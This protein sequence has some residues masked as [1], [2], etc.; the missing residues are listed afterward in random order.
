MRPRTLSASSLK[1]ASGCLARFGAE[2]MNRTRGVDNIPALIGTSVHG[3]LE[4][5]VKATRLSDPKMPWE[6]Q[7]LI[8]FYNKSFAETFGTSDQ[9]S[10]AYKDGLALTEKWF[11]RSGYLQTTEVISVEVKSNFPVKTSVGDIPVTYIW[12]RCDKIDDTTVKV[13]DYKT[14][15]VPVK[16]S[17]LHNMI[18]PRLYALSAQFQFPWAE[19]I[20]VEFDLLRHESVGTVFTKEENREMY[21]YIKAE[22]ERILAAN[23]DN[24][25]ETL[26]ADC[27]YCVRKGTCDA[28][29]SHS[30]G[31]GILGLPLI[32]LV[33]RKYEIDS[34][35]E[36]L[37]WLAEEID[38]VLLKEA[39]SQ[40]Q[41]DFSVFDDDINPTMAYDINIKGKRQRTVDTEAVREIVGPEIAGKF[42]AL[43]VTVIDKMLKSDQLT[44]DQKARIK[45]LMGV[46]WSSPKSSIKKRDFL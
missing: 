8:A 28:M 21:F 7:I 35:L 40:G 22:A 1:S 12:D 44:E 4:E 13:V 26:N 33:K 20:W 23:E 31:G 18:Q 6:K 27:R 11:D 9:T 10:D 14:I 15:R 2:N 19:K 5:F 45:Q 32:D 25:P 3:G 43:G 42:G 37:K 24:L 41:I 39:D 16:A 34:Q 38:T 29:K 17:D 46:E 30:E 36:G